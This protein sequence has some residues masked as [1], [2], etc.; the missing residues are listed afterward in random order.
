M[1]LLECLETDWLIDCMLPYFFSYKMEF[2]FPS[3]TIPKSRSI[4]KDGSRSLGLFRKGNTRIMSKFHRT[5][6]LFVVIL[7]R[8]KTPCSQI[9][10]IMMTDRLFHFKKWIDYI[11]NS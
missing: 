8:G 3:K 11:K 6:Q 4:L 9:A 2:F 1:I 5:D 7:R 10:C